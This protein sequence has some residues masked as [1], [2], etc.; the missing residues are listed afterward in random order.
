MRVVYTRVSWIVLIK[1]RRTSGVGAKFDFDNPSAI[2]TFSATQASPGAYN[3][4]LV[5]ENTFIIRVL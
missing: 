3:P 2:L 1:F 5:F 4:F